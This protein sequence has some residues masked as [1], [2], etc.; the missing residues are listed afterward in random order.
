MSRAHDIR[1]A[2]DQTD[3]E[4]FQ[5]VTCTGVAQE[6]SDYCVSCEMYWDDT[7]KGLLFEAEEWGGSE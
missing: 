1:E 4:R 3:R 5:C 6:H 2:E 7:R